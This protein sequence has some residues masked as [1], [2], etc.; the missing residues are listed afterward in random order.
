MDAGTRIAPLSPFLLYAPDCLMKSVSVALVRSEVVGGR[1]AWPRPAG[2]GLSPLG[3]LLHRLVHRRLHVIQLEDQI[4][5]AC[6]S[7]NH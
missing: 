3:P 6:G 5:S 4:L 2:L 7:V 1:A